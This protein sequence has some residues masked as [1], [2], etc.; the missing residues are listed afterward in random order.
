[1]QK[2]NTETKRNFTGREKQGM[3]TFFN[4]IGCISNFRRSTRRSLRNE[5]YNTAF[6]Y[7]QGVPSGTRQE[8][9]IVLQHSFRKERF[10]SSRQ[11]ATRCVP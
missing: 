5:T 2:V 10:V 8:I 3:K 9:I 4:F 11:L 1:M 6:F 7:S